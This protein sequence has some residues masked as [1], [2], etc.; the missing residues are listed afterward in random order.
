M[1]ALYFTGSGFQIGYVS[2]DKACDQGVDGSVKQEVASGREANAPLFE[3]AG[4]SL[5]DK[6]YNL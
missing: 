6:I 2:L 4:N 5:V 3:M 1:E